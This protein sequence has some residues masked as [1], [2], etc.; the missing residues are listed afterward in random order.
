MK[1]NNKWGYGQLFGFSAIEGPNRYYFDNILITM[2]KTGEFR[3]EYRPY[4]IKFNFPTK[5]PLSI[6]Y[7]MSDFFVASCK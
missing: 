4:W 7:I 1:L 3:F 6:K 5:S 2:H